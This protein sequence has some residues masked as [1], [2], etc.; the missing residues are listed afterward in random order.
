MLPLHI[1]LSLDLVA[2]EQDVPLV[3]MDV[4]VN[5]IMDALILLHWVVEV[6]AENLFH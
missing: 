3:Q 2:Q 5:S 6:V 4:E 1:P